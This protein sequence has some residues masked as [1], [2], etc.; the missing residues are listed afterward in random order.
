MFQIRSRSPEPCFHKAA[1]ASVRAR[2]G[3][4]TCGL[5]EG[6]VSEALATVAA[7]RPRRATLHVYDSAL[8]AGYCEAKDSAMSIL[9]ANQT[10][11]NC[12]P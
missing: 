3:R 6:L 8:L 12:C 1:A 11:S 2:S 9:R 7:G 5:A 10:S 4:S